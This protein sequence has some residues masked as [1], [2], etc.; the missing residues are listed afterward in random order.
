MKAE[1]NEIITKIGNVLQ[2]WAFTKQPQVSGVATGGM[3]RSEQDHLCSQHP[4][5]D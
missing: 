5:G 3:E 1:K 2:R 4:P